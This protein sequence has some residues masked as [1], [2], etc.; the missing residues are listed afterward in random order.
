MEESLADVLGMNARNLEC[1]YPNNR[2]KDYPMVDNKKLT[3]DILSKYDIPVVP[4]LAYAECQFDLPRVYE[5]IAELEN[6]VIKPA[7]GF[8]GGGIKVLGNKINKGWLTAS[9]KYLSFDEVKEHCEEIMFGV[10]SIDN[11][12]DQVLIEPR[13]ENPVVFQQIAYQGLPD[14]RVIVAKGQSVMAMLRLPT[15]QSDGRANLHVGGIGVGVDVASGI[16][17]HA[18]QKGQFL[19]KHPDTGFDL[20]GIQIPHWQ[21]L[22]KMSGE[23][24]NVIPLG[25]MG[26]DWV[27]DQNE[28]LFLLELNARPGIEIQNANRMGLKKILRGIL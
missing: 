17:T 14:I 10:Y 18:V 23:I 4:L 21:E 5:T 6:F 1:I 12:P 27:L 19:T 3:K 16:T 22:I 24:Q 15:Q 9:N 13:L 28:N 26:L 8:G 25:Y 2:R 20:A 11:S 7:H